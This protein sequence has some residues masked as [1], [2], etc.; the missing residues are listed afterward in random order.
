LL[1]DFGLP[2][3]AR[4]AVVVGRLFEDRFSVIVVEFG[5]GVQTFTDGDVAMK[6]LLARG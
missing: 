4:Q 6:Y 1:I 3:N 2:L 5:G